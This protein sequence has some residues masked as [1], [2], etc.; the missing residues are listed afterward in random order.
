MAPINGWKGKW[1]NWIKSF[2]SDDCILHQEQLC[3]K[4]KCG[5][6][7]MTMDTV[8][9]S[10]LFLHKLWNSFVPRSQSLKAHT[11]AWQCRGQLA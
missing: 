1:I 6:L 7:K 5:E 10:I 9:Q 8:T 11:V 2:F 3:S 4:L